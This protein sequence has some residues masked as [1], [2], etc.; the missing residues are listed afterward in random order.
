MGPGRLSLVAI[1][2][3]ALSA[4]GYRVVHPAGVL[5][6]H[7]GAVCAPMFE[8]LT[9]EPAAQALFT[10]VLREHLLRTGAL[11]RGACQVEVTGQVQWIG[12]RVGVLDQLGGV[13]SYRISARMRLA[14]SEGG[15]EL[16]AL[17]LTESED[18]L[19]GIS[20]LETEVSREAAIRRLAERLTQ[21]ALER[22]AHSG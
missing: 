8:N 3:L 12:T 14:W 20:L 16:R 21:D 6:E 18:A 11:S 4:C 19:P 10:E 1:T 5:P 15:R 9:S 17:V 22:L 13:T 7:R 2:G